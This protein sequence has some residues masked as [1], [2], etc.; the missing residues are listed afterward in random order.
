MPPSSNHEA[1]GD[2]SLDLGPDLRQMLGTLREIA[3]GQPLDI[4]TLGARMASA[5]GWR[6]HQAQ[7]QRQSLTVQ[8]EVALLLVYSVETG[9]P[10]GTCRHMSLSMSDPELL[11][12]Q[13][14]TETIMRELGFIGGTDLCQIW[15]E[16][17]SSGSTAVNVVQPVTVIH[18]AGSAVP[19]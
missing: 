6:E 5:R 1:A 13:L 2:V 16:P 11:P 15:T 9:H 8:G 12:S 14:L 10:S 3:S 17:L 4:T 19:S 18:A 7:M